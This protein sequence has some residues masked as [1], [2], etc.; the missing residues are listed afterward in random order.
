MAHDQRFDAAHEPQRESDTGGASTAIVIA[1]FILFAGIGLSLSEDSERGGDVSPVAL[2][3]E[4]RTD[5]ACDGAAFH[6]AD[7]LSTVDRI[8]VRA[9]RRGIRAAKRAWL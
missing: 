1:S 3:V 8:T 7:V 2:H 5:H 6:H 4:L 9:W